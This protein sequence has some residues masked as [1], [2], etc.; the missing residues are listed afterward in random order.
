MILCNSTFEEFADEVKKGSK[1]IAFFGAGTILTGWM[2]YIIQTCKL[3]EYIDC[4]I[5]NDRNKQNTTLMLNDKEYTIFS[6]EILRMKD[7]SKC[8]IL[9]TSSYF[10]SIIDQLDLIKNLNNVPCYIAPVMHISHKENQDKFLA[11]PIKTEKPLIPK[12]IHYCWF[13]RKPIP[14]RNRKCIDSWRKYC[15]DYEIVEWNENNYDI[16]KNLYMKQA[17]EAGKFGYVPDYARLDLLYQ[18]GGFYF[19]TD[20]ELI[21]NIDDLL[22][23]QAFTSFEEYPTINVGGG[24]GCEKGFL[25]FKKMRDT[26]ENIF[27]IKEDGT[28]NL[29]TCGYYETKPLEEEGLKLDGRLQNIQGMTIYPS[30]YFHPK[31]SVTGLTDL[32]ENTYSIHHFNWSWVSEKQLAEKLRTHE[33]YKKLLQRMEKE[34]LYV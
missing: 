7:S 29:T 10:A 23:Q 21:K 17:Y 8:V 1:R 30:D 5:D 6:P 12:V 14:E 25:L 4:C 32:T 22:Y 24:S 19:D 11:Q 15:P 33:I 3:D 16:N 26:R 2:P 28:Y 13:G 31:S 20:V 27:F 9:I 34:K 18:Y